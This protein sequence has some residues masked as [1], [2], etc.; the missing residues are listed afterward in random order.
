MHLFHNAMSAH[1]AEV[2]SQFRED[3]AGLPRA[4][5]DAAFFRARHLQL[6]AAELRDLQD[7]LEA[8][9][10]AHVSDR[11]R[12]RRGG[13]SVYVT[14]RAVPMRDSGEADRP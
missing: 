9:L 2:W 13:R 8:V 10:A 6:T 5:S 1:E 14:I 11:D 3:E 7:Q 12:E 4:W